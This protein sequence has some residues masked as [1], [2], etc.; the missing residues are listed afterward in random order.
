VFRSS[1]IYSGRLTLQKFLCFPNISNEHNNY[2]RQR[3]MNVLKNHNFFSSLG[4]EKMIEH[5][6]ADQPSRK[7]TNDTTIHDSDPKYN[8]SYQH[9][10]DPQTC[11]QEVVLS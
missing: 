3:D 7:G 9:E 2:E 5:L 6:A 4:I 8:P 10:S 11:Q 1:F